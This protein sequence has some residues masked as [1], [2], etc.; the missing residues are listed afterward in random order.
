MLNFIGARFFVCISSNKG[1]PVRSLLDG[2]VRAQTLPTVRCARLDLV[3]IILRLFVSRRRPERLE[4]N[5]FA[6]NTARILDVHARTSVR[7]VEADFEVLPVEDEL[8][9]DVAREMVPC[10]RARHEMVISLSAAL[11]H[12]LDDPFAV[13]I[14]QCLR[15]QIAA[16]QVIF[17][18]V[19]VR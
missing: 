13:R 11:V 17:Q 5:R 14:V 3:M 4:S 6:G 2:A 19:F 18:K 16:L 12:S 1:I 9:A 7:D 8:A 10:I 15:S